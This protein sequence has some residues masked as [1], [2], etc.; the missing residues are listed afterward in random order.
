MH[1]NIM[2]KI[3][4]N[5][6]ESL[7]VTIDERIAEANMHI[8]RRNSPTRVNNCTIIIDDDRGAEVDQRFFTFSAVN[9]GGLMIRP[10]LLTAEKVKNPVT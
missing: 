5:N 9:K 6:V 10:P 3:W 2:P 8:I 1:Q 4:E 7:R